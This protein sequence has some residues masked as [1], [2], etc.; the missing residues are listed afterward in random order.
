MRCAGSLS[1]YVIWGKKVQTI[2]QK[3]KTCSFYEFILCLWM[4]AAHTDSVSLPVLQLLHSQHRRWSSRPPCFSRTAKPSR[5]LLPWAQTPIHTWPCIH[6]F[7]LWISRVLSSLS[8]SCP[9]SLLCVPCLIFGTGWVFPRIL[10]VLFCFMSCV[11]LLCFLVLQCLSVAVVISCLK[12]LGDL[13]LV[14][15]LST[16]TLPMM[17][18][19]V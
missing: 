7:I 11:S 6:L 2:P 5:G 9:S 16:V 3:D 4:I 13:L 10:S 17:M 12:I 15:L 18:T 19:D 14:I 1:F 8:S